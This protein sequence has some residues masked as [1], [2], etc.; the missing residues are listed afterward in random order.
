MERQHGFTLIELMIVVAI[1]SILAAIAMPAYQNYVARAQLTAALS[2]IRGGTSSFE[3]ELLA[4]SV[5]SNDPAAVGLRSSTP[6]CSSI[7]VDTSA[8]GFISCTV[9][10]NPAVNGQ[11]MR[12]QRASAT[13]AWACITSVANSNMIPSGCQ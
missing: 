6:R 10:G 7:T 8:D 12:L 3:S 4:E 9:R 13:G 2:D 1:I 5:T 11:S